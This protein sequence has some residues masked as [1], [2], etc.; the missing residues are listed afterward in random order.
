MPTSRR[1]TRSTTQ[2]KAVADFISLLFTSRTQAHILHLQ[3]ESFAKHKA[4]NK[5]YDAIVDLTDK[6]AEAY[7]GIYG[8]IEGYKASGKFK[9][10][11]KSVAYFQKL[12][13]DVKAM[14]TKLPKDV[15]LENIY[16][17]I[18]ELIHSTTYLLKEL[19]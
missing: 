19:N 9:E 10:G 14:K 15:D 5:Y 3:T 11:E 4:L 18:L 2:K 16:A 13:R 12:E 8:I 7:Q 1:S 6:Y 17:D